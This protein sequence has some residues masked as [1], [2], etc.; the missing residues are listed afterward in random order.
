MRLVIP[1]RIARGLLLIE[2]K[3]VSKMR[4]NNPNLFKEDWREKQKRLKEEK[5]YALDCAVVRRNNL[6]KA[7][8]EVIN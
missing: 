5:E 4:K 7:E 2:E 3:A 1:E 6:T 8:G